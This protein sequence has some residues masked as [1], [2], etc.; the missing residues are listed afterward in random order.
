MCQPCCCVLVDLFEIWMTSNLFL[1]FAF[2]LLWCE[3]KKKE[4]LFPSR[5]IVNLT[6]NLKFS[7]KLPSFHDVSSAEAAERHIYTPVD[8]YLY[9]LCTNKCEIKINKRNSTRVFV[10]LMNFELSCPC[11]CLCV[12]LRN[13]FMLVISERPLVVHINIAC[14]CFP[15]W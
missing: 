15:R 3:K 12:L 11:F 8:V 9:L 5:E 4:S 1:K 10:F 14:S 6:L 7:D 2:T 13:V